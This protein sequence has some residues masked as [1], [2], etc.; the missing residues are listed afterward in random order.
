MVELA[1]VVPVLLLVFA[2][3]ADLGRAFYAYVAIE[4]AAKEGAMFGAQSPLCDDNSAAGCGGANNVVFRVQNELNANGVTQD[5][6]PLVPTVRCLNPGG[7][8]HAALVDCAEGDTYEVSLA[9]DFRLLTPILGDIVGNPLTL[10]SAASA[11]VFNLA[12]DPTPGLSV[13]KLVLVTGATNEDEIV[14]KCLEPDD[15]GGDGYYRSP[16]HDSSTADPADDLDIRFESGMEVTYRIRVRNTG[17][18]TLAGLTLTDTN[19]SP[20][21]PTTANCPARPTSLAVNGLYECIYTLTAPATPGSDP[22]TMWPNTMTGQATNTTLVSDAVAVVVE[23]PAMFAVTKRVSPYALG[24]DGDGVP[25][26][27]ALTSLTTDLRTAV[28]FPSAS[29]TVWYRIRVENVGAKPATG[30][31]ITDTAGPLPFGANTADAVCDSAPATLNPGDVFVCRYRVTYTT[32]GAK[33]NTVLATSPDVTQDANDDSS[34]TVTVG[35]SSCNGN[36][37]RVVPN[38]IDLTRTAAGTAW[39]AAGL[40]GSISSTGMVGTDIVVTQ[41]VQAFSCQGRN[42]SITLTGV[43]T[44]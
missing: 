6:T 1:L 38:L 17:A 27:G 25:G 32:A 21:P 28:T 22:E 15:I 31:Q 20:W 12:F 35:G 23:R 30:V 26:F 39:T 36:N 2:A 8:P 24:S 11:T 34:V 19:P 40:V 14:A 9:Y 43:P 16:C 3:A 5:G 18:V 29:V 41:D 4:N 33:V 42:Q 10:R 13:E 44:P 37:D 7:T